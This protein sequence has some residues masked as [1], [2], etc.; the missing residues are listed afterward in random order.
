MV[1]VWKK[2]GE[3]AQATDETLGR[4]RC[5]LFPS[6]SP[7]T[8]ACY[9]TLVPHVI[10]SASSPVSPPHLSLCSL[11]SSSLALHHPPLQPH[12]ARTASLL[13]QHCTQIAGHQPSLLHPISATLTNPDPSTILD[14]R[15]LFPQSISQHHNFHPM[16]REERML[17]HITLIVAGM[18][19]RRS[20][21]RR[22]G[23][24]ENLLWDDT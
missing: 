14:S 23:V 2:E 9:V 1:V 8:H 18:H 5:L 6:F 16:S 12:T 20:N 10:S 3:E 17:H 15:Q 22:N 7:I 21:N 24:F 13:L 11:P 4:H 19:R